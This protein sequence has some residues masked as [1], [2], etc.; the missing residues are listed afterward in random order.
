MTLSGIE[1]SIARLAWHMEQDI[2]AVRMVDGSERLYVN[3]C[4]VPIEPHNSAVQEVINYC[5][6]GKR[7]QKSFRIFWLKLQMETGVAN[8]AITGA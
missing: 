6:S 4:H 5:S 2:Q 1:N 8:E 7:A 3:G